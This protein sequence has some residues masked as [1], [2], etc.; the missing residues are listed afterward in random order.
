MI[1]ENVDGMLVIDRDGMILLANPAAERLL[2]RPAQGLDGTPFGAPLA[3]EQAIEI[4]IVAGWSPR[5]TEMRVVEIDWHGS[6]AYLASLRDVT[7]RKRAEDLLARVGAQHAAIAQLGKDAVSGLPPEALMVEAAKH[8]IGVL[9]TDF[10]GV[11]AL[12]PEG[13]ELRLVA[14]EWSGPTHPSIG[15]PGGGSQ[16]RYTLEV[17]EPVVMNDADGEIRFQAWPPGLASAATVLVSDGEQRLGVVE[18]ASRSARRFDR[19]EITFLESVANLLAAAVARFRAER[20]LRHRALHDELTGLANRTLFLD[21]L[22]HAVA[23]ARRQHTRLAV[24]FADLDGFKRVNDTIGHHAGDEVLVSLSERLIGALR[25]SDSVARFGG[26]EFMMLL[27]DVKGEAQLRRAVDRIQATV[28]DAP[29]VVDGQP[30]SLELTIGVV[31]ADESHVSPGDLVRDADAA[32][33]SAKERGRGG[34]AVFDHGMRE[35]AQGRVRLEHELRE[36]LEAGELGL[37]YQPIVSLDTGR[38][39]ELEALLRWQHPVRGLLEPADFLDVAIESR[40]IVPIGKWALP[41]ACRHAAAWRAAGLGSDLPTINFNMAPSELAQ[42]ELRAI[43]RDAVDQQGG[44]VPLQLELTEGALIE[45][46]SL[47]ATLRDLSTNLGVRTALDG[48]GTGYSS[49]A[50]LTRF[51]ID[52]LKIDGSFI[53]TL[54]RGRDAPIVA[55]IVSMAHALDI[56]IVAE[57]VETEEQATE[58]RRLGCD[59][60][61]GFFFSRPLP[62]DAIST[63]FAERSSLPVQ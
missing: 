47:S 45:D 40:L 48:F 12:Q 22:T 52:E 29:F 55:A 57:G 49:L 4:D 3:V 62:A 26:D 15:A 51:Q 24:L 53:G 30:Q 17:S 46:P 16:P 50:Y 18:V 63:L 39:V 42:P 20:E 8:V 28:A 41:E 14:A 6:P 33:Y 31:W 21:R 32:M 35:Q 27:E 61:Q 7:D 58:A 5:T 44:R 19:D 11:L 36:A 25:S 37:F 56:P 13:N 2:G 59:R 54:T 34:Y 23:R 9:A 60:G 43:V 38:I 10:A 1:R